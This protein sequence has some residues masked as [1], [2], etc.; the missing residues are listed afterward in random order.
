MS[1]LRKAGL[2]LRIIIAAASL[3]PGVTARPVESEVHPRPSPSSGQSKDTARSGSGS[4]LD[5]DFFRSMVE[6]VFL[7]ERPGHARC[8]GCHSEASRIFHLETLPA[9]STSW[10]DRKSVV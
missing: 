8:Y 1:Y 7:K 5:F 10:T 3:Y 4:D 9:G 6:P 2:G